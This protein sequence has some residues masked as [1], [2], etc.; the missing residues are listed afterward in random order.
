MLC[1]ILA[2]FEQFLLKFNAT[3]KNSQNSAIGLE[4]GANTGRVLANVGCMPE[5]QPG[6]PCLKCGDKNTVNLEYFVRTQFSYPGLS[7]LS[8]AGNFVQ[9]LTAAASQTCFVPFACILFSYGSRRV[10]NIRK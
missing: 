5:E 9:S 7:D 4:K 6:S 2:C 1:I 3:N 8:Y 10:R